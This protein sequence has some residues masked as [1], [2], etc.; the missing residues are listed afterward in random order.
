MY[1]IC[2]PYDILYLY[3]STYILNTQSLI[4]IQ[5]YILIFYSSQKTL[6]VQNTHPYRRWE[7]SWWL[8]IK[9]A[10]IISAVFFY[11]VTRTGFE[12]VNA[13]VKGM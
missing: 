2:Y 1:H 3:Y 12:P 9:K 6:V 7:Y 11:M 13:C 4:D 8:K 10:L 5:L